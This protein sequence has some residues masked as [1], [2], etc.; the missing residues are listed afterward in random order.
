MNLRI[1]LPFLLSLG[2]APA[3]T[4]SV[5]YAST[6]PE[7]ARYDINTDSGTLVKR[8]TIRVPANIQ[9]AWPH[10]SRRF[11]YVVWSDGGAAATAPGAAVA[12]R[13]KTHGAGAFRI[14]PRTGALEPAGPTIALPSR[15]IHI[16]VDH[17]GTHILIAYNDPSAVT[18]HR[19]NQDGTIGAPVSQ[20]GPLD[21]GVYGHQIRVHPTNKSAIL[22]TRGNGPTKEKAEDRGALKIYNYA[23]GALTNKDSIA[24]NGGVNYQPRHLDFHPA[25]PWV[26]VS[27]E[28]QN[29]LELYTMT[30]D[31]SFSPKPS[32]TVDSLADPARQVIRQIAGTLHVHPNGKVIYQANRSAAANPDGKA[33]HGGGENSIA[34]Y[35]IDSQTGRPTRIQ[36]A[37]TRG[38]EPRT[39]AL[40]PAARVLV[41]AN[42]TAIPNA[43]PAS[44]VVYRVRAG[45]R[46]DFANK[47]DV[48]TTAG[49]LFWMGIVPLP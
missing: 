40:D 10:P 2:L 47:Y 43:T 42:Q 35:S 45:G 6:G 33:I 49:S 46:L 5:L 26:Y 1:I 13:G 14:D 32:F 17:T 36:N 28:R 34:V 19:L 37:D 8:N 22:V 15:P 7:L 3:Q 25:K 23:N 44:L 20:S 16:T 9:Y 12:P 24:P 21:T 4:R 41:A 48:D 11:L 38:A 31:G 39:F 27:L 18:V 29:K 30:A